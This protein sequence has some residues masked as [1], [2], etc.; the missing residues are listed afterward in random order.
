[1]VSDLF[2]LRILVLNRK[3]MIDAHKLDIKFDKGGLKRVMDS[4]VEKC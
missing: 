3:T 2:V 1:M 4:F